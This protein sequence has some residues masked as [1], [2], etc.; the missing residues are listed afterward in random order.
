MILLDLLHFPTILFF[1]LS[2]TMMFFSQSEFVCMWCKVCEGGGER[3]EREEER[4]CSGG[5]VGMQDIVI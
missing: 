1:Q 4:E 2:H 5:G 3:E